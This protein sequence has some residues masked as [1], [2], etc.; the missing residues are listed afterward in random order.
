MKL[1]GLQGNKEVEIERHKLP[2]I[3]LI[4]SLKVF[5]RTELHNLSINCAFVECKTRQTAVQ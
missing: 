2:L 4:Y 5:A 3:I 1:F